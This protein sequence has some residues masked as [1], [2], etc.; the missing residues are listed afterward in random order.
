MNIT[1]FYDNLNITGSAWEW[2][3]TEYGTLS[4][5]Q[6]FAATAFVFHIEGDEEGYNLLV[7][8]AQD[9]LCISKFKSFKRYLS[10][11]IEYLDNELKARYIQIDLF[12]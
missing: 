6:V 8:Q 11:L 10:G 7:K 4:V 12:S 3:G 2:V 9:F 1:V 5:Q